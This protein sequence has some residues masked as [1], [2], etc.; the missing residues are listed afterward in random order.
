MSLSSVPLDT[1]LWEET[2]PPGG[3]YAPLAGHAETDVAVVGG[4][5]AGL[6]TALAVAERGGQVTVLEAAE[7]GAGAS[8]RNGGQVIPGLRHFR[9]DLTAAY[10]EDQGTRAHAFGATTADVTFDL[11]NRLR[12]DCGAVQSGWIQL[13]DTDEA[14]REGRLRCE[15]WARRGAPAE[16]LDRE[17]AR[18]LTGS[19]AYLGGWIDRRGGTVQPLAYAR[20]L[21]RAAAAA[22]ATIHARSPV[23]RIGRDGAC[24]S[25]TT[26]TGQLKA[27]RLLLATNGSTGRLWPSIAR[28]ILPVWS[29][30]VATAPFPPGTRGSLL[31]DGQAVSDTRRV[32]R[33]FRRDAASRLIVG[34]KGTSHA[35]RRP[36]DFDLQRKMVAR[37]YPDMADA[38]LTHLW[39]GQVALTIDRLPRI[40]AIGPDALASLGCNGKGVAWN[41]ALGPVLADALL[42]GD[43]AGLPIPVTRPRPIPFHE[44][45][46]VY[47]AA[48]SAWLRLRDALDQPNPATFK[49]RKADSNAES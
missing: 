16:P 43:Y 8:G 36:Q 23:V 41:T 15:A 38:A 2:A 45:R 37:L 4:G 11:I 47:V 34:G 48:G 9:S 13:A 7:P 27:R 49:P 42:T 26:P 30:Q 40:V 17:A 32:I 25:L 39:G 44:L 1:P 35:P 29:F 28:M 18:Q 14:M 10:G 12:L 6:S 5:Y 3:A 21:A 20:A 33:Y 24:W 31:P 46:R 22:G 19:D